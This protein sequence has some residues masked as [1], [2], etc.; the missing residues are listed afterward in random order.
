[1]K[2]LES[3]VFSFLNSFSTSKCFDLFDIIFLLRLHNLA[4][5]SVFV[6]KFACANLAS[7]TSVAKL[8]NSRVV[9][10]KLMIMI[11][12]LFFKLT[13]FCVKNCFFS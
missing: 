1:M 8:F 11:S 12:K 7:K 13:N 2:W 4:S 9:I 5:K 3:N 6:I 10:I